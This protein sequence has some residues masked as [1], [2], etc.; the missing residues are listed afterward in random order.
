MTTPLPLYPLQFKPALKDKVWGGHKLEPKL[1]LPA[2]PRNIGEAWLI[3]EDLA[4]ANGPLQGRT[5]AQLTQAQPAAMLGENSAGHTRFPLLIKFLD[6]QEWLSVQN[7]PNDDYA[8]AHEGVPFGK[9]EVWLVLESDP[10]TRIIHGLNQTIST[11][12]LKAAMR[13]GHFRDLMDYVE[14]HPNDIFM[15]THG[16]VHALGPGV[17]IYELQQSSDITYR[18]YDWDRKPAPGEPVRELHIDKGA[19]V[20]DRAPIQQH[21]I[22]PVLLDEAWGTRHV[23]VACRYFAGE[24][25]Y[26]TGSA[27]AAM[28][29]QGQS[30]HILTNLAGVGSIQAGTTHVT[31]NQGES[32][33]VPAQVGAYQ[34]VPQGAMQ[35]VMAY[36]PNLQRDIVQALRQRNVSDADILQLGGDPARSDLRAH[37]S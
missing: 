33:L 8:Q 20:A 22:Q 29:T 27:P 17:M 4:V 7:H 12:A 6:P 3:W 23:F 35:L 18:L 28:H 26:L 2:S 24:Q 36:V 21:T 9:C 34:I 31:L 1:G 30:F 25:L 37:L 15:N 5:I 32:V 10:G 11:D 16:M 14:A 19:E 13:E